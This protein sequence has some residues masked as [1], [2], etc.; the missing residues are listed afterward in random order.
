VSKNQEKHAMKIGAI[1]IKNG[2]ATIPW[3]SIPFYRLYKK[4]GFFFAIVYR[5]GEGN[6]FHRSPNGCNGLRFMPRETWKLASDFWNQ[7]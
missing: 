5:N 4:L 1:T 2:H 7:P 3:R 6:F